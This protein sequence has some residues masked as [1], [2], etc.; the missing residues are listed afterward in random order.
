MGVTVDRGVV[1]QLVFL[2]DLAGIT[3]K[4]EV[5]LDFLTKRVATDT[6][7]TGVAEKIWCDADFA[8]SGDFVDVHGGL[9]FEVWGGVRRSLRSRVRFGSSSS[10]RSSGSFA[11]GSSFLPELTLTGAGEADNPYN[12]ANLW[13]TGY[14]RRQS[15]S[16][17]QDLRISETVFERTFTQD[18][19]VVGPSDSR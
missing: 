14:E 15:F 6:A 11:V 12:Y 13:K 18:S 10:P 19:V 17:W 1:S 8:A 16:R 7:L 3:P 2:H 9:S 4:E 5:G